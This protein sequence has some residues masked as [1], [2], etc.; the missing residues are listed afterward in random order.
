M[1]EIIDITLDNAEFKIKND[2]KLFY[3]LSDALYQ[4]KIMAVIRELSTNAVDAHK[5]IDKDN[6]P[7]DVYIISDYD[8]SKC[9]FKIV[10]YGPGL[11]NDDVMTVYTTYCDS[12]KEN[13]ESNGYFGLGSK[14]PFAYTSKFFVTSIYEGQKTIYVC[15]L[16]EEKIPTINLI[17]QE[18]TSE[19]SGLHIK[20]PIKGHKDYITFRDTATEIYS[21]FNIKPNVYD[22]ESKQYK[23]KIPT[24]QYAI[25]TPLYSITDDIKGNLIDKYSTSSKFKVVIGDIAYNLAITSEIVDTNNKLLFKLPIHLYFKCNEISVTPSRESISLDEKS[26]KAIKTRL[27]IIYDELYDQIFDII[28][29]HTNQYKLRLHLLEYLKVNNLSFFTSIINILEFKFNDRL[30]I[31]DKFYYHDN[32]SKTLMVNYMNYKIINL[33][34]YNK[35]LFASTKTHIKERIDKYF[36]LNPTE[37]KNDYLILISKKFTDFSTILEKIHYPMTEEPFNLNRLS[38]HTKK[39]HDKTKIIKYIDFISQKKQNININDIVDNQ[40]ET[41]YYLESKYSQVN[42][43]NKF[44]SMNDLRSLFNLHF[45][46]DKTFNKPIYLIPSNCLSIIKKSPHIIEYSNY[47]KNTTL[48]HINDNNIFEES[49]NICRY[50]KIPFNIELI[51]NII[52]T[53]KSLIKNIIVLD[54]FKLWFNYN[55]NKDNHIA[56]KNILRLSKQIFEIIPP[57]ERDYDTIHDPL[58][59]EY[60]NIINKYPLIPLLRLESYNGNMQTIQTLMDY[61]NAN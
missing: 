8:E 41:S 57:E 25:K 38:I 55:E 42:I 14:S 50:T 54:R 15:M 4:N 39:I 23:Q 5:S 13:I 17:S 26:I 10:D 53:N 11:S 33:K 37:N 7:F 58:I 2:K 60:N 12:K 32:N 31:D 43:N 29:D 35:F 46:I 18:A 19:L 40:S 3:I 36:E 20:V 61:I 51:F 30:I 16:N 47:L 24:I 48:K 45:T 59:I 27:N 34:Y 44:Q 52:Y 56:H 21:Y 28:K 1:A 9:Y 22:T 6:I 49:K